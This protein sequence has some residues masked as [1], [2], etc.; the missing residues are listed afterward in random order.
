MTVLSLSAGVATIA[1]EMGR[2]TWVANI[3]NT[4]GEVFISGFT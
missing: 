3:R 1:Y 4:L 2:D